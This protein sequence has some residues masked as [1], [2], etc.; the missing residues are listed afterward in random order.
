MMEKKPDLGNDFDK[1]QQSPEVESVQTKNPLTDQQRANLT[2]K[3]RKRILLNKKKH[4]LSDQNRLKK[5]SEAFENK[6]ITED[7]SSKGISI[8][9]KEESQVR[10]IISSKSP[11]KKKRGN[12]NLLKKFS[13]VMPSKA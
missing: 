12:L 6:A 7:K 1:D 5:Q 4:L 11:K 8:V 10:D 9:I 3:G 2:R 13:M